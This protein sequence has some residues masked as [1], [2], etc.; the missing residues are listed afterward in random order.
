TEAE[1]ADGKKAVAVLQLSAGEQRAIAC[2]QLALMSYIHLVQQTPGLDSIF[3]KVVKLPSVWSVVRNIGVNVSINLEKQH[4]APISVSNWNL[5]PETPSYTFPLSLQINDQTAL[6]T[7]L[8]VAPAHPP[9]LECGGIIGLL[10]E[11]PGDKNT[12]LLLRILS[13]RHASDAR[14]EPANVPNQ[15]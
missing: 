12:Y 9:F 1:I 14:P 5:L 4:V 11:K 7:T 15:S 13:A 8:V 2:S 10:A 6:M 3:Y